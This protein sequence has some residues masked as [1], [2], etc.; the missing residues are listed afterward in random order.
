MNSLLNNRVFRFAIVGG[1]ATLVH[2][3]IASMLV[4]SIPSIPIITANTIAFSGAVLVSFAGHSL[5]TFQSRGSLVKFF[6]TAMTGLGC[7]NVVAY[8]I[9]SI[10]D[11]KML[12]IA[13]G[14]LAAPV[15]VYI[16]S[17]LWVFEQKKNVK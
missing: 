1:G 2:L 3:I 16:L 5:F 10:S 4:Y 17:A 13:V 12:S 7:N 9:L 6:V 8:I 15:I 11:I 14:T